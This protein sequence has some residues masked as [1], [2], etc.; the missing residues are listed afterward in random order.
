MVVGCGLCCGLLFCDEALAGDL[1]VCF[2]FYLHFLRYI[3]SV[4]R[5]WHGHECVRIVACHVFP[6]SVVS[7][8]PCSSGAVKRREIRMYSCVHTQRSGVYTTV[9]RQSGTKK[10]G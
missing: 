6:Q 4:A 9:F 7:S 2:L 8:N 1:H 10:V 3:A 5:Q